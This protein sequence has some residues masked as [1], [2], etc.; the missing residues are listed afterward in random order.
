MPPNLP[1]ELELHIL[2]LAALSRPVLIPTLMR[3]ARRV[4]HWVEP[5]LYLTLVIG[6]FTIDGL[7]FLDEETITRI[8]QTKS[9]ALLGSVRN[10]MANSVHPKTVTTLI[11][12]CPHVVN[13]FVL[14]NELPSGDLPPPGFDQLSL[15]RIYC[16]LKGFYDLTSL[17]TLASPP[18]SRLTHLEVFNRLE[19]YGSVTSDERLRRWNLLATLPNLTH[20]ALGSQRHLDICVHLL[21]VCRSLRALVLLGGPPLQESAEIDILSD[22][23]RFVMVEVIYFLDDWQHETLGGSDYWARVDA[24][25]VK[26]MSGEINRRTFFLEDAD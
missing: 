8:V 24:F 2:E 11:C 5:L 13:L 25:I 16:D 17:K 15:G 18:L 1:P 23:P 10:V 3:V 4:K 19:G 14:T 20:L 9:P 26:R 12:A 22:D 7:P 21:Q 6:A